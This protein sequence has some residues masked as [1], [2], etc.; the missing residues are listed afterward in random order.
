M[1]KIS[2]ADEA[3]ESTIKAR[4]RFYQL[5]DELIRALVE[6]GIEV[7]KIELS[8]FSFPHGTGQ[9]ESSI[10]G[11]FNQATHTGYVIA[12]VPYAMFV[13]YGTGIVGLRSP[14]HPAEPAEW[15]QD[16]NRHGDAGWWYV[17]DG[18][19]WTKGM[20]SRPFMYNAFIEMRYQVDRIA[21]EVFNK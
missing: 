4:D 10:V 20:P 6:E 12:D 2:G 18:Y 14:S 17:D 21:K 19:H 8:R 15:I 3:L 13:E 11:V 7:A 5:V 9:L 1:I 16:S